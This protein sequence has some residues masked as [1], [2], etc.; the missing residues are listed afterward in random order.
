MGLV[1]GL[2]EGLT[3]RTRPGKERSLEGK[4]PGRGGSG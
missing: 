4:P 1:E 2:R 3:D